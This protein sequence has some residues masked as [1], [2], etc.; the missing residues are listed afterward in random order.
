L[1]DE[2]KEVEESGKCCRM[3]RA[4]DEKESREFEAIFV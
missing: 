3:R 2:G 4:R 1:G